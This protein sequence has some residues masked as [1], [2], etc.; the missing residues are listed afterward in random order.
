MGPSHFAQLMIFWS[1]IIIVPLLSFSDEMTMMHAPF[2][3]GVFTFY[4]Y[5]EK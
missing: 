5:K 4:G 3:V 1:W 2:F